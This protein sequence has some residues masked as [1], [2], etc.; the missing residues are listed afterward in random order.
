[1]KWLQLLLKDYY[2][3]SQYL[4]KPTDTTRELNENLGNEML[5]ISPIALV[6]LEN[7]WSKLQEGQNTST[8]MMLF[9]NNNEAFYDL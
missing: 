9:T 5:D 3:L 2:F 6:V 1:M 7:F 8:Y 4:R